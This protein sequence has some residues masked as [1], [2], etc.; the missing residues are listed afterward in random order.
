MFGTHNLEWGS[1]MSV[2]P[3]LLY[4][5]SVLKI[6]QPHYVLLDIRDGVLLYGDDS[7][8]PHMERRR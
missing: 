3:H 7:P 6:T 2:L 8:R 1:T 4:S 5:I